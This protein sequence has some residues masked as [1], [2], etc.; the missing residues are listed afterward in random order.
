[1]AIALCIITAL[2]INNLFE[3]REGVKGDTTELLSVLAAQFGAIF[4]LP[5]LRQ[6][7]PSAPAFGALFDAID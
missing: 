6:I 7:L 1:M 3:N 2:A 4:T 5:D